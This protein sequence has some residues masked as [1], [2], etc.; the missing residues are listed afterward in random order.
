MKHSSI[1][2]AHF[3]AAT[4]VT[5]IIGL[6][7]ATVQQGHRSVANDPQ[8]QIARDMAHR[9]SENKSAAYLFPKDSIDLSR[10]LGLFATLYDHN[11]NPVYSSALLDGKLPRVPKGVLEFVKENGED[12]VTWQPNGCVRMA[13]VVE[14]VNSPQVAAVAVG[15]SLQ[16]VEVRESNLVKMIFLA[17]VASMGVIFI[18]CAIQ[19]FLLLKHTQ[20]N[21]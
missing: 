15:R 8:L 20:N 12:A 13:M 21:P 3:V 10:S 1:I 14:R 19:L 16:E 2:T 9:L 5:I 6:V 17:L 7:Y 11:G 4:L 18:H